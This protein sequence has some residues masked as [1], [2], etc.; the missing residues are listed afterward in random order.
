VALA[1]NDTVPA[2]RAVGNLLQV[3]GLCVQVV[4][5]KKMS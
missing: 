3:L 5:I 4:D 2:R 1:A